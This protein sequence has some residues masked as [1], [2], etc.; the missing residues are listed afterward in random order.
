MANDSRFAHW[1]ARFLAGSNAKAL[2]SLAHA[3]MQID[4]R[5]V[6]PSVRVPTLILHADADGSLNRAWTLPRRRRLWR[7]SW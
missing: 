7:K 4:I 2:L 6:L 5:H 1:W 3:N